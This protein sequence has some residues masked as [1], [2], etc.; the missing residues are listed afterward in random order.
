MSNL[1]KSNITIK[2]LLPYLGSISGN[3]GVPFND[4]G[5][6]WSSEQIKEYKEDY[7][8]YFVKTSASILGI[9]IDE[10]N[11]ILKRRKTHDLSKSYNWCWKHNVDYSIKLDKCCQDLFY[12]HLSDSRR[13]P[14]QIGIRELYTYSSDLSLYIDVNH[15]VLIESKIPINSVEDIISLRKDDMKKRL[16]KELSRLKSQESKYEKTLNNCRSKIQ[17]LQDEINSLNL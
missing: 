3:F 2:D 13:W 5:F 9:S 12:L 14:L 16:L 10:I 7:E 11:S 4:F 17:K 8:N 6:L 1:I 15:E